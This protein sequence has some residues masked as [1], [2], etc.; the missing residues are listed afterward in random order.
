MW[1]KLNINLGIN[2]LMD[3]VSKMPNGKGIAIITI[4]TINYLVYKYFRL[5]SVGLT[6]GLGVLLVHGSFSTY[7]FQGFF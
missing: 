6:R 3:K 4:I 7:I 2:N 1:N 5:K